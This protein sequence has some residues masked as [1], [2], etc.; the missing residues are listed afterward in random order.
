MESSKAWKGGRRLTPN[1]YVFI[2]IAPGVEIMEHRLRMEKHLGRALLRHENVH[3][4][5]GIKT[6]NRIENLELWTRN[7]PSGIRVR[8]AVEHARYILTLYEDIVDKL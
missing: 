6:D 7:Q 5:N 4:K 8:D 3:H 1:G 2:R